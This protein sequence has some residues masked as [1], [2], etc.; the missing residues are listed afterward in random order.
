MGWRALHFR[1]ASVDRADAVEPALGAA[2]AARK[3]HVA[4]Q[5]AFRVRVHRGH[6]EEIYHHICLL[7][8]VQPIVLSHAR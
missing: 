3:E 2:F 8:P 4:E 6:L 7:K 5:A 1:A